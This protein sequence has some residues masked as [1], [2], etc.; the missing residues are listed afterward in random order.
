MKNRFLLVLPLAATMMIPAMAQQSS[1]TD[2][3][4]PAATTT[5]SAPAQNTQ[6]QNA[7]S[8]QNTSARQPLQPQLKQ[9][10]WGHLNPFARKKYLERQ[11]SPIRNRVNELDELTANNSKALTDLDARTTEGLKEA[12]AKADTADQHAVAAGNAAQQA[13][14][15]ATQAGA[16]LQT[17]STV[18]GNIDQY[19]PSTQAEIRFRPGQTALSTKAKEALDDMAQNLKGQN[20]YIIEVQ[21]FAPGRG[22]AAVAHSKAMADS[23]VRYLVLNHEIPVYRIFTVGMG[24][25]PMQNAEGKETRLR[26]SKVDVTLMKNG[27]DQLATSQTGAEAQP[28]SQQPQQ[29]S[30]TPQ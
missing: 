6:D 13:N 2:N 5:Q 23:V 26:Y 27:I 18:V 24:N 16:R 9:G 11:I 8:D 28:Q 3:Q 22:S 15:T 20:G 10:F 14:Q 7:S 17:V 21:G 1:S 19:K 25:A 12:N 30:Q 4:Q 29:M